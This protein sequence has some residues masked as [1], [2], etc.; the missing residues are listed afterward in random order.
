MVYVIRG[1]RTSYAPLRELLP[2]DGQRRCFL[3]WASRP[4]AY[5]PCHSAAGQS[6]RRKEAFH[7][8]R[9]NHPVPFRRSCAELVSE[10]GGATQLTVMQQR[11]RGGGSFALLLSI[12]IDEHAEPHGNAYEHYHAGHDQQRGEVQTHA[13]A[14]VQQSRSA[15]DSHADSRQH[16]ATHWSQRSALILTRYP[17]DWP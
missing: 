1:V 4:Q 11:E 8:A 9:R 6:P 3:R 16:S 12:L 17:A 14:R 10:D 7:T 15:L 13:D 5:G 2:T